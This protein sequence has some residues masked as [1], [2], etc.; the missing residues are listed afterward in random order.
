MG[1]SAQG[2]KKLNITSTIGRLW[3]KVRNSELVVDVKKA[4]SAKKRKLARIRRLKAIVRVLEHAIV[5][6]VLPELAQIMGI[7]LAN[8]KTTETLTLQQHK[9]NIQ[10]ENM[11][12]NLP[13]PRA[14]VEIAPHVKLGMDLSLKRLKEKEKKKKKNKNSKRKKGKKVQSKLKV[15]KTYKCWRRR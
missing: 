13:P 4:R 2:K 8:E 5:H 6:V 7:P 10:R 12:L 1:A 11:E 14:V 15:L 9:K 3:P